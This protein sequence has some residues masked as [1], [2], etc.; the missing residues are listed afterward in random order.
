MQ[1]SSGDLL[2]GYSGHIMHDI[3]QNELK[4]NYPAGEGWVISG[5]AKPVGNDEIFL[6]S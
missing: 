3:V 6:L 5:P 1:V 4:R 2:M